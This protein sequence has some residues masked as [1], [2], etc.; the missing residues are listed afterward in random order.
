MSGVRSPRAAPPAI[1]AM[2]AALFGLFAQGFSETSQARP[3]RAALRHHAALAHAQ[4]QCLA[5]AMYWEA[6]GEGPGGM[7][8]VGWTVLN[9]MRSGRFPT[10]PCAVVHQ[11]KETWPCEFEFWCDGRDDTPREY[12]SWQ[13]AMNIAAQLLHDPPPDPTRGALYFH[14][15]GVRM[16]H[17]ARTRKIGG[18]VFYR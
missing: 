16:P 6:R 8:A 17:H 14:G 13:S 15:G 4:Q 3:R 12:D 1:C 9:R 10:T 18:H 11:G 7:T 2:L 5:M